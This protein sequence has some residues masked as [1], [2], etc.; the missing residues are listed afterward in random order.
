MSIVIDLSHEHCD[1]CNKP[2]LE[3]ACKLSTHDLE[4]E[5]LKF[6][7]EREGFQFV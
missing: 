3:C 1:G 6:E 2:L 4:A 7:L 5:L